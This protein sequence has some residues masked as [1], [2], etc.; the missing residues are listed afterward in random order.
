ME[1]P[2]LAEERFTEERFT[3]ELSVEELSVKESADE[4]PA[5]LANEARPRESGPR[6]FVALQLV[7]IVLDE[8]TLASS[9]VLP[10]VRMVA[11]LVEGRMISHQELLAALGKRMRQHS[12]GRRSRREYVLGYLNQHPPPRADL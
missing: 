7:D 5:W 6:E 2:T 1:S 9:K 8:Q 4:P 11:S 10:Y 3:E 12:I